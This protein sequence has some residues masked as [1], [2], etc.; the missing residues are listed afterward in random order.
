MEPAKVFHPVPCI[1]DRSEMLHALSKVLSD[2]LVCRIAELMVK[3][4]PV[5][6]AVQWVKEI[7]AKILPTIPIT[8][9]A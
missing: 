1:T 2:C 8:P 5:A 3:R 7:E 9:K 6:K 4:T